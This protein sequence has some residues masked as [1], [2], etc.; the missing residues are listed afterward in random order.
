[1]KNIAIGSKNFDIQT[2]QGIGDTIDFL[3]T[4]YHFNLSLL[5]KQ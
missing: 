5:Y 1:M 3:G 4:E 2:C